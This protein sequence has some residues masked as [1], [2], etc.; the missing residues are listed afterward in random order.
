M[1]TE[2]VSCEN[3]LDRLWT[4]R[5]ISQ[6]FSASCGDGRVVSHSFSWEIAEF[7]QAAAA[8]LATRLQ[9]LSDSKIGQA[10]LFKFNMLSSRIDVELF[11]HEVLQRLHETV[12]N[13]VLASV[14]SCA[15]PPTFSLLLFMAVIPNLARIALCFQQS[16]AGSVEQGPDVSRI[17]DEIRE[18]LSVLFAYER[19]LE[20]INAQPTTKPSISASAFSVQRTSRNW[21]S[22]MADALFRVGSSG[23]FLF[24]CVSLRK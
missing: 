11:V 21:L 8:A 18:C 14:P 1:R 9:F 3:A 15:S 17:L 13:E 19:E 2:D 16:T 4:K 12:T 20:R 22:I 7:N 10:T 24:Q 23:K 6:T 5:P